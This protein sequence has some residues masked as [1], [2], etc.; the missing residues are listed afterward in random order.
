MI[1]R[2]YVNRQGLLLWS[3]TKNTHNLERKWFILA[4]NMMYSHYSWGITEGSQGRKLE[5]ETEEA[6]TMGEW[7]SLL[8]CT[9]QDQLPQVWQCPQWAGP[10]PTIIHLQTPH[11]PA[12]RPV[13]R[14]NLLNWGSLFL[15]D[16]D[17]QSWRCASVTST[18]EELKLAGQ[19]S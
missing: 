10:S 15:N 3:N 13:L 12:S 6:E 9:L 11:R 19:S 14:R 2:N 16:L 4:Y 1:P 8:P 17:S 18:T 7:P 5:A